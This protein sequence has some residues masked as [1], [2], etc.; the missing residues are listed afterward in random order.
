MRRLLSFVVI[1]SVACIG[2]GCDANAGEVCCDIAVVERIVEASN[3]VP[4]DQ[5]V[6][7]LDPS[8]LYF[9]GQWDLRVRL[10][11]VPTG[12]GIPSE[13]NVRAIMTSLP[14]REAELVFFLRRQD[15]VSYQAVYWG[16]AERDARG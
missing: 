2:V 12:G 11:R 16:F 14:T 4:L 6:S 15:E 1:L 7:K 8:A 10:S 5:V 3:F 13:L 9:G